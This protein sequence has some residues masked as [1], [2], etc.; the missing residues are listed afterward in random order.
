MNAGD[1]LGFSNL[2][3]AGLLAGEEF[4]IRYGVRAPL[5]SL[6]DP[7]HI[8]MRQALIRPLR[9][10]VPAI[11]LLTLLTA[12]AATVLDGAG[13]GLVPRCAAVLALLAWIAVTLGGTVPI[14]AAAL[15]WNP[16]APPRDWRA[17]VDRWERLN[18][19]RAWLAVGAFALMLAATALH[20][21]AL[22][23]TALHATGV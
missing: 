17:Q 20:A 19:V 21:T 4:V 9:L 3:F 8:R 6:D 16:A 22:H 18:S 13:A 14:N 7:S 23:A 5:A 10:L 11:Y 12:L 1:V 2:F 15:D